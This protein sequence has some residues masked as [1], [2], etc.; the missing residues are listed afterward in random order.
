[1]CEAYVASSEKGVTSVALRKRILFE[2]EAYGDLSGG[3]FT[4][5]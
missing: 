5:G 3:T 2:V 4:D 1:M